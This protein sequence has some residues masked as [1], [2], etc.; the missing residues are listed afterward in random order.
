MSDKVVVSSREPNRVL[1]SPVRSTADR[2]LKYMDF[3][4]E[5]TAHEEVGEVFLSCTDPGKYRVRCPEQ[6][7]RYLGSRSDSLDLAPAH[8]YCIARIARL[9]SPRLSFQSMDLEPRCARTLLRVIPS[10]RW[11]L[12]SVEVSQD[13]LEPSVQTYA[14]G[15][16]RRREGESG[17]S[18]R[19]PAHVEG[20]QTDILRC[21][22]LREQVCREIRTRPQHSLR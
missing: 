16:V 10:Q 4:H 8:S 18:Q 14:W 20:H 7:F 5:M 9:L 6:Y 1:Q 15:R 22:G 3:S 13:P 11:N 19:R 21:R 12:P 2:N 17:S